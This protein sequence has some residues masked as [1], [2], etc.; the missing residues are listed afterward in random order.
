MK[1]LLKKLALYVAIMAI[2]LSVTVPVLAASSNEKCEITV[3][4]QNI[5]WKSNP[6]LAYGPQ[7]DSMIL[8]PMKDLF[9]SLGYTVSY[10]S[11][12]NRSIF[13]ADKDSA[14]T[15]FYA[16][17]KTGQILK[18][19][20][21]VKKGA[22]NS[23]YIVNNTIYAAVCGYS[24]DKIAKTFLNNSVVEI[25]YGYIYTP[26]ENNI[27]K[28]TDY[29]TIQNNLTFLTLKIAEKYPDRPFTGDKYTKYNTGKWVSGVEVK[30]KFREITLEGLWDGFDSLHFYTGKN[31]KNELAGKNVSAYSIAWELMDAVADEIN[32]Q[33]EPIQCGGFKIIK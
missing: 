19:G 21:T 17:L 1:I 13:T 4:G 11:Q 10:D 26:R 12:L 30:S 14:Y 5:T 16:D 27:T 28:Y 2:L 18:E 32:N 3:N 8:I 23:V 24:L 7:G 9:T 15:S 6:F 31:E 20:D 33:Y 22:V 25:D 29:F